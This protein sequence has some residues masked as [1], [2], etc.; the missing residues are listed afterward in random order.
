MTSAASAASIVR[1][2]VDK[3]IEA[4]GIEEIDLCFLPFGDSNR[5]RDGELALDLLVV[6]IRY[7]IPFIRPGETVHSPG[8]IEKSG[9][10]HCFPAMSMA[11]DT[12][13][14]NIL[15]FVNFQGDWPPVP[16]LIYITTGLQRGQFRDALRLL[17]CFG[18]RPQRRSLGELVVGGRNRVDEATGGD[19]ADSVH[20]Q[21][22]Y[23]RR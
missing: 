19:G 17:D 9:R 23:R 16:G 8:C 6:E 13:I 22:S 14:A 3:N 18:G 12:D 11:H 5:G 2:I 7:R 1:G 10:E 20:D 21:D 15:A 4:G